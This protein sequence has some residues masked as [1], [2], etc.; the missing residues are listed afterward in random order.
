[1]TSTPHPAADADL[2]GPPASIDADLA[3]AEN[4]VV[5]SGTTGTAMPPPEAFGSA[6]PGKD[7]NQAG[8][9]RERD[10]PQG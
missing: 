3:S 5:P 9:V 1:M 2:L 7:E 6:Q 10:I 8:F 4:P